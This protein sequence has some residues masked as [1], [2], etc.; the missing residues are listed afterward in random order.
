M[1][2]QQLIDAIHATGAS[3]DDEISME[4]DTSQLPISKVIAGCDGLLIVPRWEVPDA[5]FEAFC[6][7]ESEL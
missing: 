5:G 7:E 1:T 4:I 3:L 2:A 6:Q